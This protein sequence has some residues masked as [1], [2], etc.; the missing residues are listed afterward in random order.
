MHIYIYT[1]RCIYMNTHVHIYTHIGVYIN[2]N[3]SI[4]LPQHCMSFVQN[5]EKEPIR[6][7][8]AGA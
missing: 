3:K 2:V 7:G 5:F 4:Y 8:R 1:Y 6:G